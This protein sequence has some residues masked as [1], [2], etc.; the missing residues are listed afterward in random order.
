[1]LH[2]MARTSRSSL[3]DLSSTVEVENV[4]S[5]LLVAVC[6]RAGGCA[7]LVEST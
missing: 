4:V 2:F 1:M 6:V 7:G 3:L 5:C